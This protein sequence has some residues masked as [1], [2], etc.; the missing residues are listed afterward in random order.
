MY[1]KTFIKPYKAPDTVWSA[2]EEE[3][4]LCQS[5]TLPDLTEGEDSFEWI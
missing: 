1:T 5:N 4:F 3:S 2:S